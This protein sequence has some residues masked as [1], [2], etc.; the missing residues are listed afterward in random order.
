MKTLG[1]E[2]SEAAAVTAKAVAAYLLG[3]PNV[4]EATPVVVKIGNSVLPGARYVDTAAHGDSL[5]RLYLVG[6]LPAS[7]RKRPNGTCYTFKGG[8]HEWYVAGYYP[9]SNATAESLARFAAFHPFGANVLLFAWSLPNGDKIDRYS[10]KPYQRIV[11]QC[12]ELCAV[13]KRGTRESCF[14]GGQ[15]PDVL[16]KG[17]AL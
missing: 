17:V 7:Y 12:L 4:P 10:E 3:L 8:I 13:C 14:C 5:P 2:A 9:P 15:T 6:D 1:P 11:A 16:G